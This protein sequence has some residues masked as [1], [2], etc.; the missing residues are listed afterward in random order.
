M[1]SLFSGMA[2]KVEAKLKGGWIS[3]IPGSCA[4]FR[5]ATC[6]SSV[7]QVIIGYLSTYENAG[8]VNVTIWSNMAE[9]FLLEK[10]LFDHP[11]SIYNTYTPF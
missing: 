11:V 6:T 4:E 1:Q 9:L 10:Q 7:H 3:E 5:L 2:Y 8:K